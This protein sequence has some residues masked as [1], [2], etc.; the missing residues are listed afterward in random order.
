M[1][2]PAAETAE[3]HSRILHESARLFR[4]RGFSGVSVGE[5]MKATGL[6]HGPFYNHFSSKEALMRES[7]EH[8]AG[9]ALALLDEHART[10]EGLAAYFDYYLSAHHCATPGEGCMLAAL[11]AEAART[12]AV[13]STFSSMVRTNI[14]RYMKYLPWRPKR[15]ARGDTIRMMAAMAGAVM[16]ARAVDDPE[17]AEE[18]LREVR[19]GIPLPPSVEAGAKA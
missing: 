4:E 12:P 16:L 8:Q 14:E 18:I 10:P 2:Y 19:A 9:D 1:R 15:N 17:L 6:T 5:I 11:S 13:R 7:V 3:K